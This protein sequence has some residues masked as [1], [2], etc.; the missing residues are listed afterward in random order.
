MRRAV[1]VAAVL[2]CAGCSTDRDT[3]VFRVPSSS[4]EPTLHC[5][6]PAPGCEARQRD[7]VAVHA[8]G[9]RTPR[10]GDIVVFQ[11]PPL[12]RV[13]CGAGGLFIKR[14]IGLPGERW[15]ERKGWIF[16]DGRRLSEPYL[17][18]GRR[19][20]ETFR[21]GTIPAG[22]YLLLGDNRAYSCDSRFW[23]TVSLRNLVGK[24]VEIKRGSK[25]IHIR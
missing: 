11:T 4:M 13:K 25:D 20:T 2:V 14:V 3:R 15:S 24:V 17:R 12:A 10:R 16:S 6:R 8:Y 23:G 1:A 19:D 9:S 7:L 22:K 21:G 5:A 18:A